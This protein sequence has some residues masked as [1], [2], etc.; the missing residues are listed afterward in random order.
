[1]NP[2]INL[3][4]LA[5]SL[6]QISSWRCMIFAYLNFYETSGNAQDT[7]RLEHL[8]PTFL[9]S[10][11]R[12]QFLSVFLVNLTQILKFHIVPEVIKNPF[13]PVRSSGQF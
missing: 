6:S 3:L 7:R 13:R 10:Q 8:H 2:L 1:M 9:E 5:V 11:K 4:P 12:L